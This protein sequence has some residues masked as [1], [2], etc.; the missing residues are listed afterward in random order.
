MKELKRLCDGKLW[1]KTRFPQAIDGFMGIFQ[2]IEIAT[3]YQFETWGELAD[4]LAANDIVLTLNGYIISD[5]STLHILIKNNAIVGY[6]SNPV[7]TK[8][9]GLNIGYRV[10]IDSNIQL[11]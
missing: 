11:N 6:A 3:A 8:I 4:R 1:R 2:P 5:G 10:I 9:D 7:D